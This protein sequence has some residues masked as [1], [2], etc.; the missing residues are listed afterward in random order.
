MSHFKHL[1]KLADI[2]LIHKCLINQASNVLCDMILPPIFFIYPKSIVFVW[3]PI[4]GQALQ[5][6]LGYKYYGMLHKFMLYTCS[7][8]NK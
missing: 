1:S 2:K 5:T 4:K 7:Y 6:S 8:T 3:R